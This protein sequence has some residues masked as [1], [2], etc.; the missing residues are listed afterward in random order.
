MIQFRSSQLVIVAAAV[1]LVQ[2][3]GDSSR[4]PET[5]SERT[6]EGKTTTTVTMTPAS[7]MEATPVAPVETAPV[8]EQGAAQ[9]AV[10]RLTDAQIAGVM[11][12]ANDAE[13]QQA[14]IAQQKAKHPRVKKFAAMMISDHGS[15]RK[16]QQALLDKSGMIPSSS[17]LMTQLNTDAQSTLQSLQSASAGD[18]DLVYMDAQIT[19]H[20]QVLVALDRD[21]IPAAQDAELKA[22]LE[23]V[24]PKIAEHLKQAQEIRQLLSP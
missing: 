22:L 5:I 9:P 16:K 14:R 13:V 23:E 7:R 24:R 4:T 8:P 19:A 21:L 17:N 12:A 2:C 1:M 18:F 10:E 11:N 6:V 15:A 3:G 20:Q